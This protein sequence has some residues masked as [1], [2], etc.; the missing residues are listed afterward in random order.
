MCTD[1]LLRTAVPKPEVKPA[2]AKATEN[3]VALFSPMFGRVDADKVD[4]TLARRIVAG[5]SNAPDSRV[6]AAGSD[7]PAVIREE[8]AERSPYLFPILF[9]HSGFIQTNPV[10]ALAD[11]RASRSVSRLRPCGQSPRQSF[12]QRRLQQSR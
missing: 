4:V 8:L 12:G 5:R 3:G 11:F 9:S 7:L 2:E 6:L 1:K 10:A